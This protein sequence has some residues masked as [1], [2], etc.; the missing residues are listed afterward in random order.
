VKY[1][2]CP[3]CGEKLRKMVR[4]CSTFGAYYYKCETACFWKFD[5]D[6]PDKTYEIR[7]GGKCKKNIKD[8]ASEK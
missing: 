5:H 6:D 8:A 1:L 7:I 3:R 4:H 2:R